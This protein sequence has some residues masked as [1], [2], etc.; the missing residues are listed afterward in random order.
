MEMFITFISLWPSYLLLLLFALEK[1]NK[2]VAR[3]IVIIRM[4]EEWQGLNEEELNAVLD[5]EQAK[6]AGPLTLVWKLATFG[7]AIHILKVLF[8]GG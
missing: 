5:Q 2:I 4:K 3:F 8:I 7:A 1:S 6:F